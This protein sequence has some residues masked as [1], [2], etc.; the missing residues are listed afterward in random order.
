MCAARNRTGDTRIF[1]YKQIAYWL[2]ENQ[3]LV[4]FLRLVV[5]AMEKA[6]RYFP[7]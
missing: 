3:I 1:R 4:F 6:E 2:L 5:K 7:G